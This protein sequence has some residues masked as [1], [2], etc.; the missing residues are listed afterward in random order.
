MTDKRKLGILGG[1]GPMASVIFYKM[2]TE[3]TKATCDQDHLDVI[4]LS[5][6]STP[7]RTDFITGKCDVSPLPKMIEGIELLENAGAEI[8]S[9]P[10]NTAHF[11]YDELNKASRVPVLNIVELTAGYIKRTG[12]KRVGLLA[13]DGTIQSGSYKRECDR[14]GM[15]CIVPD[16]ENQKIIMDIIYNKIKNN[17]DTDPTDFFKVAQTLHDQNC[18]CL[19]IGCTE[20]SLIPLK[21]AP[22]G[23]KFI[24]SLEVLAKVSIEE[25]GCEP[26]GFDNLEL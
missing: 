2:I 12:A 3:H 14:L 22:A 15:E 19:L 26:I 16:E 11:F 6:A 18:D 20:L 10:C 21:N 5:G 4:V 24:D 13:T 23:L 25:C 17:N 7:D 8:I 9:V 1:L